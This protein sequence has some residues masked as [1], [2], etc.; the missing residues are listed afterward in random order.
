MN[1]KLFTINKEQMITTR[2]KN[3]FRQYQ[4]DDIINDTVKTVRHGLSVVLY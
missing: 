1:M 2:K 4:C 3:I